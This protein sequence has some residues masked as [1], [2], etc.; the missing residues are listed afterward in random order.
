[1]QP[2]EH[3]G[4]RDVMAWFSSHGTRAPGIAKALPAT[5]AMHRSLG[6]AAL[7]EGIT[8]Q[9]KVQVL[10]LGSAV[11]SNIDYLSRFGCKLF[12]E[13]LY[14]AIAARTGGASGDVRLGSDFF[15][16]FLSFPADT[17]F[18]AVLAWDLFNYLDREELSDLALYLARFCRPGALM[19]SL[20]TIGKQMP[21]QPMRFRIVDPQHLAYERHSPAE[22][23][24]PRYALYELSERMRGFRLARSFLMRHGIQEYLFQR[25]PD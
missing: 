8:G 16:D 14:A 17:C 1:L 19:L 18:D 23:P 20:V 5:T 9:A 6:L 22:R 15:A 12:I 10:D 11:G 3:F 2:A 24:C 21:Q 25:M 7:F 13:D 4:Q